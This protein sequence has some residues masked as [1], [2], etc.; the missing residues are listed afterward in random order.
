MDAPTQA[1]AFLEE[2]IELRAVIEQLLAVNN[3]QRA[4]LEACAADFISDP[5]T[6]AEAGRLLSAEFR[7]RMEIAATALA[8]TQEQGTS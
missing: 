1:K 6:V 5:C 2:S 7:R 4:A 3:R 8:D